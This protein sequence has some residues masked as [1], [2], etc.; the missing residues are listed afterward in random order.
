MIIQISE[1]LME[2]TNRGV[3]IEPHEGRLR[4]DAP[5]G[6]LTGIDRDRLI[7]HKE[8]ILK[9]LRQE[10]NNGKSVQAGDLIRWVSPV[11]GPAGPATVLARSGRWLLV[12]KPSHER[13][14]PIVH[15]TWEVLCVGHAMEKGMDPKGPGST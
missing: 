5:A 3:V 2:L 4:I 13:A 12:N 10:G 15:E 8:A 14:V 7:T 1:F 6:L 11:V 9:C